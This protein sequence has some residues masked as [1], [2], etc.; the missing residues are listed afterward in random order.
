M[1]LLQDTYYLK[2]KFYNEI[3]KFSKNTVIML[4]NS[5]NV[6]NPEPAKFLNWTDPFLNF[7]I[8]IYHL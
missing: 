5:L 8:N 7:D 2:L 3:D 1:F 4:Q 6:T